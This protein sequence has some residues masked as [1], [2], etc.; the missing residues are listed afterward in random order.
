MVQHDGL[1]GCQPQ[2]H[3]AC[4]TI[5]RGLDPEE[6]IKYSL[7]HLFWDSWPVVIDFEEARVLFNTQS[8]SRPIPVL[9][10]VVEQVAHQPTQ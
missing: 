8:Q 9:E 7:L 2:P 3:T 5:A 6:R 4:V 1:H 10:G